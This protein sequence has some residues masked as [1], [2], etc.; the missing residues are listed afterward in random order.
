MNESMRCRGEKAE[1]VAGT[2]ADGSTCQVLDQVA[3]LSLLPTHR[4]LVCEDDEMQR[5]MIQSVFEAHN[6]LEDA[7]CKYACDFCCTG[8]EMLDV[9]RT[10]ERDFNLLIVDVE[11]PDGVQGHQLLPLARALISGNPGIVMLSHHQEPN[12]VDAC[13]RAGALAY[14]FKPLRLDAVAAL[15]AYCSTNHRPMQNAPPPPSL[16]A[17]LAGSSGLGVCNLSGNGPRSAIC[18]P[19]YICAPHRGAAADRIADARSEPQ[20][21]YPSGFLAAAALAT[22]VADI[23]AAAASADANRSEADLAAGMVQLA[24]RSRSCGSS[25][26]SCSSSAVPG[27]RRSRRS[28]TGTTDSETVG[29]CAQQ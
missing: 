10:R 13:L 15:H 23:A 20:A 24:S 29:V 26:S 12:I 9:L 27:V 16:C 25:L 28:L 8:I 18:A 5:A 21:S 2:G 22:A 19:A 1:K 17:D 7:P 14:F 4:V 11:L 6:K 3:E